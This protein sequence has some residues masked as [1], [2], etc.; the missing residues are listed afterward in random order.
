MRAIVQRVTQASVT[1]EAQTIATITRGYVV[2]LGIH[3]DDSYEDGTK[4]IDK[5]L[6]LR[7]MD[8]PEG[9]MNLS[10]QDANGSL[11]L[12][13]QF[14]LHADIRKGRRPSFLSAMRP[15]ASEEL[16]NKLVVYTQEQGVPVETGQFGAEMEVS[17]V[18]DGPV[19]IV[20]DTADW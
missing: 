13:S 10:L 15:P 2:L 17:L 11:L 3:T 14:T 4:L 7:I 9:K 8:D 5:L 19:T 20:L 6:G 12:I 16:Y 1:V 18:N